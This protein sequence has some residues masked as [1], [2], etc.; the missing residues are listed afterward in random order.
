MLV[1]E[2]IVGAVLMQRCIFDDEDVKWFGWGWLC[3]V[4]FSF[5]IFFDYFFVF[6][7]FFSSNN[8]F[9]ARSIS[10]VTLLAARSRTS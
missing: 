5:V 8:I 1:K 2:L 6:L 4:V 10:F 7:F 9:P 3:H